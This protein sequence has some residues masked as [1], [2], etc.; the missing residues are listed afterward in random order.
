MLSYC[1]KCKKNTESINPKVSKTT[2]GKTMILSKCA[3]CGSKKSKF[4][5]EQQVEGLL[6]NL[7]IRTPLNKIPLLGDI[8]FQLSTSAILLSAI[9]LYKMN[10][11]IN[12]FLLAGDKFM[13]EMHLRQPQFTCSACGP[14][15]K[16]KQRIQKFKE[17]GD[18]NDIYKNELDKACF[19]HDEAYPDSKDLTK[20]TVA[21]KILRNKA[22]NIAKD[23][24]YDGYQRGL[25]SVVYKFF[26][27]KSAWLAD[28]STKGSGVTALTN[29]SISQ[30]QQLAEELHKPI[31]RKF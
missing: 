16:H 11:I 13:P 4:I 3:I 2:N 10:N 23:P 26:D 30:N 6:S 17:T 25:A 21:D 12:N 18:T 5:K 20:R 27:K 29:K 1:L 19:A 8:L 24:K 22:F 15:T 7:G 14:F 31:I 9:P 28:K